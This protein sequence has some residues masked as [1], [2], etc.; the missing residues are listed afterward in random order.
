[1]TQDSKKEIKQNVELIRLFHKTFIFI[2]FLQ[3][4]EFSEQNAKSK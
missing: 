1:M 4:Y 3:K 2:I